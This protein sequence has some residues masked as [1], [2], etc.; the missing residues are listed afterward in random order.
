MK[1]IY[2][3]LIGAIVFSS[4]KK[5]LDEEPLHSLIDANAITNYEK[6]QAA[7]GGIYATFQNDAWG[8][9]L[10]LS[11]GT[12][13]GF[14]DWTGLR[15]YELSYTESN[16]STNAVS[17]WAQFYKSLNAANFAIQ[18][19]SELSDASF[20]NEAAKTKLIAEAKCLRAWINANLLW[21]FGHWWAEDNDE[22]GLIYREEVSDITNIEKPR[23]SVGESYQKIYEDLDFAIASLADFN[24]SRYVSKQFAKVLKAQLLLRR[25]GMNNNA[26]ELQSALT[27]VNDVL[28]SLP[29]SLH[30]EADLANVYAQAWDA[31]E[32]LFAK[33]L[34]DDGSR[35]SKG[36][37]WYTYG[38]IY[39][40]NKLPLPPGGT[41]TAGLEYGVDWFKAD[42]RWPIVTGEVRSPETWDAS[43]NYTFSKLARLGSYAGRQQNEE[44]Y[45]AYYFRIPQLYIMK[46]ELL[47]RTGAPVSQAI[48]PINEM[49]SMRTNPV[50]PSINPS[51]NEALMNDIFKEY[52]FE[53]CFE[54]GTE[55]FT[56][57]R[58]KNNGQPWI[59]AIK[60]GL[61][62]VMN[63]IC[64]PIPENEILNNPQVKQNPDLK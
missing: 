5:F 44:K 43:M 59:V 15:D 2:I 39:Q 13:S 16:N 62:L 19:I 38:M 40:G 3:I 25:A 36:G 32:C 56:S 28:S 21:N 47:A 57:L 22:Y 55:L 46:A 33:Y 60:G 18:G 1:S 42:P 53:T 37:Y 45:A 6:A 27:L 61:P 23:I 34:E 7:V 48:A 20:P 24:S 35:T 12:K 49:R 58:F 10:Y 17:T 9:A 8:G 14:I 31:D 54:N 30:I 63:K 50:L 29:A 52:F 26:S 64:W 51:T 4:C 41:L 11:M